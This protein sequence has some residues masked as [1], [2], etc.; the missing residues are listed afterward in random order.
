MHFS[1]YCLA[2]DDEMGDLLF[3][4]LQSWPVHSMEIIVPAQKKK[5]KEP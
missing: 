4:H 2:V 5:K 3:F 1:V